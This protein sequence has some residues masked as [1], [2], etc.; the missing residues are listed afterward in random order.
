MPAMT[1]TVDGRLA[2]LMLGLCVVCWCLDGRFENEERCQKK[3]SRSSSLEL[4]SVRPLV[5]F[6]WES[7]ARKWSGWI[8]FQLV[9]EG[10]LGFFSSFPLFFF[11]TL[12]LHH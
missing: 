7:P 6:L 12:N 11:F 1:S 3:V 2:D 5:E 9:G 10:T 8:F 4:W